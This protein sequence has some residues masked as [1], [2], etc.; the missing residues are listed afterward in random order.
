MIALIRKL[1]W[2]AL[3]VVFTFCFVVIFEHGTSNF[4][5][6]AQV[7]IQALQKAFGKINRPKDTSDKIGQ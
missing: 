4:S 7:E 1:F 5:Q 3:F 2:L 6:N